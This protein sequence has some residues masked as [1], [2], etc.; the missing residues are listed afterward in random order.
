MRVKIMTWN[1][2]SLRVRMPSVLRLL[3]EE[4]PDVLCL[5]EIKARAEDVDRKRFA[6]VGYGWTALRGQPGYNGVLV[7][8]RIPLSDARCRDCCGVG[9]ARH[10]EVELA[11]GL[12]LANFYVPAGGDVPDPDANPKFAHKLSFLEEMADACRQAPRE[13][14][15]L[16]GD[17][18]VAPLECDVWSHRQLRDVVSHTEPETT[19]LDAVMQAGGWQDA[20][21]MRVPPPRKLFSWWSYR[22]R[23]WS[24][25]DRGRRLDHIWVSSDLAHGVR[26]A[27]VLRGVRG[28]ER[29]SDHAPVWAEVEA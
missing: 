5:Q 2:N 7:L 29:P 10:L 16:V 24:A 11:G 23:D 28:W 6:A 20:V 14:R 4:R 15:I 19:R 27:G 12:R 21:R 22:A 3:A 25:S 26:A 13:R 8:S 1:V 17:L 9:E 18:N